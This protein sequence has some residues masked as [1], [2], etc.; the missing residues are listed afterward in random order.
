M[1]KPLSRCGGVPLVREMPGPWFMPVDDVE[2]VKELDFKKGDLMEIH[3][4]TDNMTAQGTVLIEN[5]AIG[6]R[7]LGGLWIRAKFLAVSDPYLEWW[8]DNGEGQ[9]NKR[10][11]NVHVCSCPLDECEESKNHESQEFHTDKLREISIGDLQANKVEWMKRGL[12]A[13]SIDKCLATLGN[14]P[15]SHQPRAGQVGHGSELDWGQVPQAE[16]QPGHPEDEQVERRLKDLEVDLEKDLNGKMDRTRKGKGGDPRPKREIPAHRDG[17]DDGPPAG[18]VRSL[19][20]WFGQK[21]RPREDGRSR[22]RGRDGAIKEA[23]EKKGRRKRRRRS[24]SSASGA[25]RRGRARDRGP[26]GVGRE[27]A[28]GDLPSDGDGGSDASRDFRA[29]SSSQSGR[30]HQLQLQEYALRKPGRLA[31]RLL[32]KMQDLI[33]REGGPPATDLRSNATPACGV[34]CFPALLVPTCRDKMHLR[35]SRELRTLL[36]ALDAVAKGESPRAASRHSSST[37][38]IRHGIGPSTWSSFRA[39]AQVW[40]TRTNFGWLQERWAAR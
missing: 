1:V 7:L 13:T 10:V 4:Y 11:F 23:C 5:L 2:F 28:Y 38:A 8:L 37:C 3:V 20:K 18:E 17:V 14:V 31:S 16:Q 12:S 29:G 27:V 36:M 33:S 39:R 26:F 19:T 24:S 35:L 22:S 21:P 9:R 30:S 6:R 15:N 32:I 34:N 40:W 25:A